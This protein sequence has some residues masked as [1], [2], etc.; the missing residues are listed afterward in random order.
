MAKRV[1]TR[2]YTAG[3]CNQ[4]Q[5]RDDLD[6]LGF[7]ASKLWNV[8]RW[9]VGRV[10]DACG[11]IPDDGVLK[12]YLKSHERYADLNAQSSQKVLEELSEAFNGWYGHRRN[13]NQN[14]NPPGYRK[15]GDDHPRST[16]T[17]KEDGF[18]HDAKYN[19]VRLSK[20]RNL[21]EHWSDFILCKYDAG[22]NVTVENVQQVRAV[23]EHGEWRLH[24]V[25]RVEIDGAEPPGDGVAGIDLGIC[26]LA[27]VSY[28]DEAVVYPG[29]ALKED[30]YYFAK[31]RAETGDSA[32][33]EAKRLDRKR[34]GRLTHFLHALSKDIISE[35]VDRDIGTIVVGD[36]GGIREDENGDA[37][38]WGSHGNLDLHGWAFDRFTQMLSYKAEAE[39]IDVVTTSERNTSKTCS[40]CGRSDKRQRVHRGLYVCECGFVGNADCNGAE[41]IRQKVLPNPPPEDRD[42]GWLAQ[43]AVRL[44]DRSEGRFAPREQATQTDCEP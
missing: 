6:S 19:R 3:I 22:P 25:C 4:R 28:G 42:N 30:E 44:F 21:K 14:A 9:T 18:K 2:T 7:A 1:V 12:S 32:S 36:L 34:T 24:F 38:N 40:A 43:P 29:G 20:G 33:R 35:C 10:W 16:V 31:K 23:Y 39:S 26:N 27:T 11:Q 15:H 17:F 41:N 13:G 37:R 5:V 8:A